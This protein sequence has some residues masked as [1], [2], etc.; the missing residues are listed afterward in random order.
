MIFIDSISISDTTIPYTYPSPYS[1]G[2][3]PQPTQPAASASGPNPSDTSAIRRILIAKSPTDHD[4]HQTRRHDNQRCEGLR[5][6][7]STWPWR[8]RLSS[9]V[10]PLQLMPPS[11][12][13]RRRARSN[14]P[15]LQASRPHCVALVIP[16]SR[17]GL[18]SRRQDGFCGDRTRPG[19]P[20]S[21]RSPCVR[22]KCI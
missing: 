5:S 2:F 6:M 3:P 9:K 16:S 1:P 17:Q 18:R 8:R 14:L 20:D 10:P 7:R 13:L 22:D 12:P 4:H 19:M 11:R 15:N 21:T